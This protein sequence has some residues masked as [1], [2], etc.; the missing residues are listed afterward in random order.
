MELKDSY[1]LKVKN[2]KDIS[3]RN[4]EYF[5]RMS[6][7]EFLSNYES[8]KLQ[9]IAKRLKECCSSW[10]WDLYRE[11]KIMDLK[12][13]NRCKNRFCPNCRSWNA[14]N[15]M[16]NFANSYKDN[17][18]SGYYPFLLTLTVPNVSPGEMSKTIDKLNK[19]FNK[20]RN[21]LMSNDKN[22]LANRLINIVGGVRSIEVTIN[23]DTGMYHIHI[24]AILFL[25]DYIEGFYSKIYPN[26]YSIKQGLY[27]YKSEAD[28]YISDLW[29]KAYYGVDVR[30]EDFDVDNM[31]Q[32]D[33][34]EMEISGINEVFKY[35]FK[36][37]DI[38]SYEDFKIL[39]NGFYYRRLIS[40]FGN[41]KGAN[42]NDDLI[43]EDIENYLK[44]DEVPEL[45][46]LNNILEIV[47]KYSC[48]KKVSRYSR[49]VYYED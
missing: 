45:L 26:G 6:Q 44:F 42:K 36:D 28:R 41:C 10:W 13:L 48:Y 30:L 46:F 17:I 27:S 7:E 49:D 5:F 37:M 4:I 25:D 1:F 24:H 16:F 23:K 43:F 2:R 32:V 12:K 39:Y 18:N 33:I 21:W 8:E 3:K 38:N 11:N 15:M 47:N 31:L 40:F 29:T 20:L 34:R 35:S 19:S 14:S 9:R 22:R